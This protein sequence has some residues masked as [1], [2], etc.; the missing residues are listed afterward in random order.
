MINEWQASFEHF[1]FPVNTE[2][3]YRIEAVSVE[4]EDQLRFRVAILVQQARSA[5]ARIQI[6]FTVF[7]TAYLHHQTK[8][9]V[10]QTTVE[11]RKAPRNQGFVVSACLFFSARF[12]A[13]PAFAC[14][15]RCTPKWV[16]RHSRFRGTPSW[17]C[18]PIAKSSLLLIV[19]TNIFYLTGT[20]Y[21]CAC[22][23]HARYGCIATSRTAGRSSSVWAVTR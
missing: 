13:V 19:P 8:F 4:K 22:A 20:G 14:T 5:A 1:L 6:A 23:R 15:R 16:C 10:P 12:R 7:D 2:I 18:L 9:D 11:I 17:V 21:I 3:D